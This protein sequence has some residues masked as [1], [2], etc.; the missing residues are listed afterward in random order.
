MFKESNV[1]HLF[2]TGN[3]IIGNYFQFQ[4]YFEPILGFVRLLIHTFR[5]CFNQISKIIQVKK[6][7]KDFDAISGRFESGQ[8]IAL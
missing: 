7:K 2:C 4:I 1:V 6:K 5:L 8:G 3:Y